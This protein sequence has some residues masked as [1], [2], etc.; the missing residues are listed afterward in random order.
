MWLKFPQMK[1]YLLQLSKYCHKS[2]EFYV[3]NHPLKW[4]DDWRVREEPAKV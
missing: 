1:I 3:C 4:E 2:N